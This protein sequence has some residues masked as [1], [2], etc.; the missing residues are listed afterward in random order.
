MIP[1]IATVYVGLDVAKATCQMHLICAQFEFANAPGGRAK[2]LAKLS[3]VPAAH[4]ACEATGGY[5]R[6]LLA[7]LLQAPTPVSVVNP[8]RMRA[9][10]KA[11]GQHAKSDPIDA[12]ELSDFVKRY[13]TNEAVRRTL[14]ARHGG[15]GL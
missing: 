9:A 7:D 5:E 6:A 2:M 3:L 8:A 14:A 1:N 13:Q 12:R 4:V 11:R 15:T 10:A